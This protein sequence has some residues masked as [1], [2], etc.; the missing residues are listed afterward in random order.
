[1]RLHT[2]LL[3]PSTLLFFTLPHCSSLPFHTVFLYPS[4][5]FFPM[6]AC[7][8][9]GG[10]VADEKA[11][12]K[13]CPGQGP[14]QGCPATQG[15]IYQSGGRRHHGHSQDSKHRRHRNPTQPGYALCDCQWSNQH[16]EGKLA[17]QKLVMSLITYLKPFGITLGASLEKPGAGWAVCSNTVAGYSNAFIHMIVC[18]S[19]V[20][21]CIHS[22]ICKQNTCCSIQAAIDTS[23]SAHRALACFWAQ[24]SVMTPSSFNMCFFLILFCTWRYVMMTIC[25][26]SCLATAASRSSTLHSQFH[27]QLVQSLSSWWVHCQ[28]HITLP[29]PFLRPLEIDLCD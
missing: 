29:S 14:C 10:L 19:H 24:A 7:C 23:R 8:S 9:V 15:H 22:Y 6:A 12:Q 13:Q 25:R 26:R 4:T 16:E 11:A 21:V 27:K 28:K 1:M 18:M 20:F 2:V 17:S 5:L 3:Y